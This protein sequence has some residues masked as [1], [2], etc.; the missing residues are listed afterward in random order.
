MSH[1][2]D[3]KARETPSA[4]F[5]YFIYDPQGWGFLYFKSEE[6]RDAA[7]SS[8]IQGYCDDGWDEEV[9]SVTAGEISHI[10][11][12]TD[13]VE[14]PEQVDEEGYDEHGEYWAE[15]WDCKCS[16]TLMPLLAAAPAQ[17]PAQ[18]PGEAVECML[19][20]YRHPD[21]DEKRTV[22]ITRKDVADGMEDKLFEELCGQICRCESVG[23]TNIVECNCSDYA[24][25]FQLLVAAP[26]QPAAQGEVHRLRVQVCKLG[27]YGAAFDPASTHYAYTY[28]DQPDNV[29]A[30]KLGRAALAVKPG[31]DEIDAGLSLLDRLSREGF[32]VFQ[33]AAS[34]GQEV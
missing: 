17:P 5:R 13:V 1:L 20:E 10:C 11:S 16:Y 9:T 8:V 14:R 6:D 30:M 15:E 2:D 3:M 23:E 27:R 4:E 31:G 18:E 34:T 32:G 7:S 19:F 21:S 22:A 26:A 12:K 25:E 33:I 28:A 24:D 29:G